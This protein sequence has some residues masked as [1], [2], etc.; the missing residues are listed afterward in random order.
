MIGRKTDAFEDRPVTVRVAVGTGHAAAIVATQ[1]NA[2]EATTET[3]AAADVVVSRAIERQAP[4][5]VAGLDTAL[6]TARRGP[7]LLAAGRR[8]PRMAYRSL[9][10]VAH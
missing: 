6:T 3:Q 8:P 7:L 1:K 2:A 9:L 10:R 4:K 5:R